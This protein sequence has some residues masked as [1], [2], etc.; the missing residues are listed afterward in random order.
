VYCFLDPILSH[1]CTALLDHI[2]SHTR[3][4]LCWT[5]FWVTHV[6]CST[7]PYSESHTV[8]LY[9][10]TIQLKIIIQGNVWITPHFSPRIFLH[11]PPSPFFQTNSTIRRYIQSGA[12]TWHSPLCV[13]LVV[14][15][16]FCN[17]LYMLWQ[18]PY[19]NHKL[20]APFKRF[21]FTSA[22]LTVHF[23]GFVI[24]TTQNTCPVH[25]ML[26]DFFI[27]VFQRVTPCS[28]V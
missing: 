25:F 28:L 11:A 19:V 7:G 18:R 10:F 6:Y 16:D 9:F 23:I 2:P 14:S 5:L 15:S 27:I 3:V 4:L 1:T 24:A 22:F 12:V 13:L 17:I 26:L 21:L 20:C 8:L